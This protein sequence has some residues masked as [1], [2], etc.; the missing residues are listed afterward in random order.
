MYWFWCISIKEKIDEN[1][2]KLELTYRFYNWMQEIE[3]ESTANF[4]NCW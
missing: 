3:D 1:S 2:G 4:D